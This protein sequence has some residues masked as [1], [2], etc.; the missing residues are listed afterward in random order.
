MADRFHELLKHHIQA[1]Y[2]SP[3]LW[4]IHDTFKKEFW[5]GGMCLFLASICQVMS[6]FTLR[7]L[8]E[9]VQDAYT[10][11]AAPPGSGITP[12]PPIGIGLGLV[13]GIMGLQFIQSVGTNQFIYHGFMVG[14]QSRAVLITAIFEK[15]MR[16]SARARAQGSTGDAK[17]PPQTNKYDEKEKSEFAKQTY[18]AEAQEGGGVKIPKTKSNEVLESHQPWSNGRIMSMMA[19]DTSRIDQA[20]GMFHL[21]WTSPFTILLSLIILLINLTYSALAGFSLLFLGLPALVMAIKSLISKRKAINKVTDMRVSLIQEILKS[22]RFVKYYGWESAFRDRLVKI[23]KQEISMT[24]VLL[25]ARNGINAFSFSL[26]IFA[27]MLSFITYS[28][29]GH[30][31]TAARVFSSLALF[32]ALRV[33]FNLLPVVI[34]QVTDAWTSLRR[35]EDFL[36][37]EEQQDDVKWDFEAGSAIELKNANF[38]WEQSSSAT[39]SNEKHQTDVE[40]KVAE[41]TETA[42]NE[43]EPFALHDLDLKVSR[44]ELIAVIGTVGSGKSSLLAGLAGDMRA[45]GGNVT[46]GASRAFCPQH[47]WIQNTT[48]KENILFGKPM[49][50]QWYDQ[51]IH[52]CALQ[53]DLD[54]LPAGD[55]TG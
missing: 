20:C 29:S 52:A 53:P 50:K 23:R 55:D 3:L 28:V 33:P 16:I 39:S 51:V 45:T 30:P 21:I 2:K 27:S 12:G 36:L 31:L 14:G 47:A 49:D 54:M 5:I 35:I 43:G 34:G 19:T 17:K 42:T 10:S 22:I 7:Y 11:N 44:N 6:P 32:S 41:G 46:L 25:T 8:I 18:G 13:F 1:G 9:F 40:E 26:P 37:A 24:Q 48:L 38:T 15:S 4:A